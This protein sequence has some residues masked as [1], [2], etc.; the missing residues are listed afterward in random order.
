MPDAIIERMAGS[1]DRDIQR[2]TGI[3]IARESIAS[4]RSAVH[5]VQVSA[6]FGNVGHALKVLE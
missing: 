4:I 2:Q 6:P 5:G 3:E 1:E